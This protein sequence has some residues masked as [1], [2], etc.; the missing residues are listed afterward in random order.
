MDEDLD[1]AVL[2]ALETADAD[3]LRALHPPGLRSGNSEILNW[4]MAAGAL[5]GL[6]VTDSEYI[7]VHRTPAGT[8]V[9]LGFVIWQP[10]LT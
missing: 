1:R 2:R 3:A 4:V 6:E 10:E 7:P 8:G 9:G 5:A